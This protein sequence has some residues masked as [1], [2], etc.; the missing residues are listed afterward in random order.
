MLKF[1][2][3]ARAAFTMLSPEEV[4]KSAR[5]PIA[6][7]LVATNG[8]GYEEMEGLLIPASAPEETR[9][10]LKASVHRASD[11]GVPDKVDLVLYEDGV[12]GPQGTY[13][14][15]RDDP[16]RTVLEIVREN[17]D[18]AL[19][20]A[21]QY[22]AFRRIVVE[23]IIQSVARE[24]AFFAIA[25]ALPDVIPSLIELPWAF[26]EFA[27]DTAFL[28]ANQIRMA[29]LI[30]AASDKEIG[31]AQQKA[32]IAGIAASAFGWRAIA[33]ELVGKI[34]FGG[35]LIPKGAVAYAVTFAIGKGLEYTH[36]ANEPFTAAQ[37]RQAYLQAYEEGKSV[38][39]TIAEQQRPAQPGS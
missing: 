39:R 19:A 17:D 35:G 32:E 37:H 1:I 13:I 2:K 4:R 16:E 6:F 5:Q 26:G 11:P 29:F 20:L 10:G 30:A 28:T 33:R 3:Q 38:A 18:I 8:R 9:A 27:S 14:F 36:H 34:P 31:F 23:R 15:H 12:P 21:R 24:N 22:P 7:G 25:T